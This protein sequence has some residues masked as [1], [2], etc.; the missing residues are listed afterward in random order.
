MLQKTTLTLLLIIGL[1]SAL[2]VVSCKE[3]VD[4]ASYAHYKYVNNTPKNI[5]IGQKMNYIVLVQ[6]DSVNLIYD[7]SIIKSW[8]IETQSIRNPLKIANYENIVLSSTEQDF[9]FTFLENDFD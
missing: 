6:S 8:L 9:K 4:E 2:F 7:N 3:T 5:F 1:I